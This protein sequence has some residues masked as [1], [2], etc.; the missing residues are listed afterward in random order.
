MT[1]LHPL[2]AIYIAAGSFTLG[3]AT[4]FLVSVIVLRKQDKVTLP[5]ADRDFVELERIKPMKDSTKRN[6]PT[7][8]TYEN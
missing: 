2:T 8:N 1:E 4:C 7:Q 3:Y 6:P 5:N